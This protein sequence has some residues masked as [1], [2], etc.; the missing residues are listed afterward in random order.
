M[1]KFV[2]VA[3]VLTLIGAA[4][5]DKKGSGATSISVH[6]DG[7]TDRYTG[8]FTAFFPSDPT[9]HPG[10]T[11][12]FSIPH[13]SGEPHTITLGTLVDTGVAKLDKLGPTASPADQENAP[14]VKNL[15]DVF[16]HAVPKNG[17]PDANQSAAQPCFLDSGIP[18]LS[19]TGSA[20]ACPKRAQPEFN[21]RQSFYNGG[22]LFEDKASW[23]MKLSKDIKPGTYAMICL[24]HRG[25]MTGKITVAKKSK[26]VPTAEATT[27]RGDQQFNDLVNK[28]QPAADNAAKATL[29]KAIGG[30]GLPDVGNA[31]VAQFGPKDITIAAGKSVTWQMLLFHTISLNAPED[32]VGLFVKNADGSVH[33]NPKGSPAAVPP[34]PD[35]YANFPPTTDKP[36]VYDIGNFDGKGFKNTATLGSIP[37][38]FISVKVTF[39]KAGT[40]PVRCLIHPDMKATVKVT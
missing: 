36:Y 22:A 2:V 5:S 1:R 17:P 38:S 12:D 37:P 20:P 14:E 40:Y 26:D 16:N 4:C 32:A 18:P 39:T 3:I 23:S 29:D 34:L 28:L 11:I 7:K 25:A 35:A 30:S 31:I 6:L 27:A 24:I 33:F 21:G 9:V 19:E 10:A 15:P 8:A 13:F